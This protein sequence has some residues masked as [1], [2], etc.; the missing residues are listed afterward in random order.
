[1]LPRKSWKSSLRIRWGVLMTQYKKIDVLYICLSLCSIRQGAPH[2]ISIRWRQLLNGIYCKGCAQGA[3]SIGT[4]EATCPT[5]YLAH[6]DHLIN[7]LK[8]ELGWNL[9]NR[10]Y[11]SYPSNAWWKIKSHLKC[12]WSICFSQMSLCFSS[13]GGNFRALEKHLKHS[14]DINGSLLPPQYFI[15]C[16]KH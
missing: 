16:S 10:L 11:H 8:W 15:I 5:N 3:F 13:F 14:E 7:L 1:M 2:S 4:L 12:N 9:L 6:S